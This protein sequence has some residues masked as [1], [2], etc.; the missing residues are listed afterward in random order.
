MGGFVQSAMLVW[1]ICAVSY[2]VVARRIIVTAPVL[3]RLW[4]RSFWTYTGLDLGLG[5]VN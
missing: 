5:L 2:V 3:F 1:Y 4:I